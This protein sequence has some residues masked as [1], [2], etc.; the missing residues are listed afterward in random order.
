MGHE[1]LEAQFDDLAV[2]H[3]DCL[4]AP[5]AGAV[6]KLAEHLTG[7]VQPQNEFTPILGQ[8]YQFHQT[9]TEKEDALRGIGEPI[10]EIALCHGTPRPVHELLAE[11]TAETTGERLTLAVVYNIHGR[12]NHVSPPRVS[13]STEPREP[14][15]PALKKQ[16]PPVAFK[17]FSKAW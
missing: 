16:H 5:F 3:C 7:L 8:R 1:F 11:L 13:H 6:A 2:F 9:P 12:V 4:F 17:L 10:D 14:R 15:Q